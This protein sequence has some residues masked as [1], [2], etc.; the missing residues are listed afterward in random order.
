MPRSATPHGEACGSVR[1]SKKA[2]TLSRCSPLA[3]AGGL[4]GACGARMACS[5]PACVDARPQPEHQRQRQPTDSLAQ[6]HQATCVLAQ[7]IWQRI[8]ARGSRRRGVRRQRRVEEEA[9]LRVDRSGRLGRRRQREVERQ[10]ARAGAAR[11]VER[12]RQHGHAVRQQRCED[13]RCAAQRAR[14]SGVTA[15]HLGSAAR[16]SSTKEA[17]MRERR[18]RSQ[19]GAMLRAYALSAAQSARARCAIAATCASSSTPRAHAP[20]SAAA[21]TTR[22]SPQPTSSTVSPGP[23]AAKLRSRAWA[24]VL[25][26]ANPGALRGGALQRA[27][28]VNNRRHH[29]G[30]KRVALKPQ[31]LR[32]RHGAGVGSARQHQRGQRR[33]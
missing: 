18:Q 30:R 5:T 19:A 31:P 16:Y 17:D 3:P 1:R 32:S 12:R 26:Q 6:G 33:P 25:A 28:H 8:A 21:T 13:H 2:E 23:T 9:V 27:Q 29:E 4:Q 10:H 20:R 11:S 22:P 15:A 7:R 24:S 14:S